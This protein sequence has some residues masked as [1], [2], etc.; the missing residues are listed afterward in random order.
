MTLD[1]FL[2]AAWRDHGDRAE[3]V[4]ARL[5]D[6]LAMLQRPQ[7]FAPFARLVTHVYGE[8]LGQWQRG[9]EL[10]EASARLPAFAPGTDAEAALRRSTAALRLGAGDRSALE[11][12]A[13]EDRAYALAIA[14][15]A[16][17]ARGDIARA[18]DCLGQALARAPA[19]LS[20]EHPA[21]RALA[22]CGNNLSA[23]LEGRP[24][25]SPAETDAMLAAAECGLRYWKLVG[26][27]LE[28]ERALYQLARCHLRAGD[29]AAARAS[30]ERCIDVCERND[31]PPFERFFGHAVRALAAR[32]QGDGAAFEAGRRAALSHYAAIAEAD[33]RWCARER[34]ELGA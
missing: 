26:T 15:D 24:A 2:E 32:A 19:S 30:I 22:I 6:A 21:A 34:D 20:K 25:L 5:P 18:I 27:W 7:D 12:L 16:L 14:A 33:R 31:A 11:R 8:H 10:L 17:G 1:A 23:V 9:V 29:A 4:A 13:D 3:D 28:E